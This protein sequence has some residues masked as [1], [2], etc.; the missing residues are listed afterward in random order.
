MLL[1]WEAAVEAEAVPAETTFRETTVIPAARTASER[2]LSIIPIPLANQ[3]AT[4]ATWAT[5]AT[6]R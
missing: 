2:R 5:W 1:G 3:S 6:P 4:R